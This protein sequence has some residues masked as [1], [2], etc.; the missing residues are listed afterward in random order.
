MTRSLARHASGTWKDGPDQSENPGTKGN[1]KLQTPSKMAL[2][3]IGKGYKN[4][5]HNVSSFTLQAESIPVTS[6]IFLYRST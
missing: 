3:D 2:R 5:S 1:N 6:T 4:Q